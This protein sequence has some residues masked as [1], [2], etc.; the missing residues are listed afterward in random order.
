MNKKGILKLPPL[1]P[2]TIV[3]IFLSCYQVFAKDKVAFY[4]YLILN[5]NVALWIELIYV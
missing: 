2:F 3:D 1:K 5:Y 4:N